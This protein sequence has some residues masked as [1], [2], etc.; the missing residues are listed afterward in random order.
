MFFYDIYVAIT[1]MYLYT[2]STLKKRQNNSKFMNLL[3][4][5]NHIYRDRYFVCIVGTVDVV[6]EC[7]PPVYNSKYKLRGVSLH[8]TI[9]REGVSLHLMY[10][11]PQTTTDIVQI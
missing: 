9:D 1:Y 2:Y 6:F 5:V 4:L 3:H 10:T 7:V 8:L 11:L